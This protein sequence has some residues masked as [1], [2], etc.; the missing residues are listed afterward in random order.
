M[1]EDFIKFIVRDK[2]VR[3]E[4]LGAEYGLTI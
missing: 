3:L 2:V 1:L 4:D